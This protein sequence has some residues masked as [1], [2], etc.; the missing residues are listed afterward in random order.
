MNNYLAPGIYSKTLPQQPAPRTRLTS[1]TGFVGLASRGPINI[2]QRLESWGEFATV[3]GDI[4][5][6]FDLAP[7]VRGFFANGGQRCYVTRVADLQNAA[8]RPLSARWQLLN[9]NDDSIIEM[10]ASNEGSWANPLQYELTIARELTPITTLSNAVNT[11]TDELTVES[12][13]DL[14]ANCSLRLVDHESGLNSG[15][16][17]VV[18]VLSETRVRLTAPISGPFS[19]QHTSVLARGL[20]LV[21]SAWPRSESFTDLSLNPDHARYLPTVVNAP[22]DSTSYIANSEAGFSILTAFIEIPPDEIA[23]SAWLH[24]LRG[25]Q[26]FSSETLAYMPSEVVLPEQLAHRIEYAGGQLTFFGRM[27][28][29]HRGLLLSLSEDSAY[30]GAIWNLFDNSLQTSEPLTGLPP[31]YTFPPEISSRISHSSGQLQ[32]DG[33]MTVDQRDLLVASTADPGFQAAI[34]NLFIKS[35]G[36]LVSLREGRDMLADLEVGY[37]TGYDAVGYFPH[38]NPDVDGYQGL[39]SFESVEEI[40]LV[41][42]PDL[43]RALSQDDVIE[44][45]VSG[46]RQLLMHCTKMADRFA[47]LDPPDLSDAGGDEVEF[48]LEQY[49]DR[50]ASSPDSLNGALYCPWLGLDSDFRGNTGSATGSKEEEI[51]HLPPSGF[52]AGIF[53]RTDALE[54]VHRSPANEIIENVI[55]VQF[56]IDQAALGRLNSRSVNCIRPFIGRGIRIWGARSLS[57]NN[58]WRYISV[59]RT[60]LTIKNEIAYALSWAT[61]EPNDTAL[62]RKIYSALSGYLDGLYRA[63]VLAGQSPEQA[64]FVKCDAELNPPES[65]E[66][67]QVVAQIGFAP[68]NP[69]EFIVATIKRTAGSIAVSTPGGE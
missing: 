32:F 5:V 42:I 34:A 35:Q 16:L 38:A 44:T 41:A 57:A 29:S 24:P 53:A 8:T 68:L 63:N 62:R 19:A 58:L 54:G 59:R 45:F 50:I 65:I 25:I 51:R 18:D 47:I 67:G 15:L 7:S 48:I 69:A 31:G 10:T 33:V 37:Y 1:V 13:R 61:F 66:L 30:Q 46:Q 28:E 39:A 56:E 12:T 6:D 2:P 3:F 26:T 9:S 17:R 60:M 11:P 27:S 55:S 23:P 36:V 40:S 14:Y 20:D 22:A 4:S 43:H 49:I 52:V 64:Y 21:I